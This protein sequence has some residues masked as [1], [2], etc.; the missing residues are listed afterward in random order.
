MSSEFVR[1]VKTSFPH[2][3]EQVLPIFSR[4]WCLK[5]VR[6]QFFYLRVAGELL[7]TKS[8]Q[9]RPKISEKTQISC[10]SRR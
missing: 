7:T 4:V 10:R 1:S 8:L 3:E 6:L 9:G 5:G 2:G